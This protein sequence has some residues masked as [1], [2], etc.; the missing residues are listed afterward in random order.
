[1]PKRLPTPRR[2]KKAVFL[3]N[4]ISALH[5]DYKRFAHF[6]KKTK[7]KH[8]QKHNRIQNEQALSRAQYIPKQ[9]TNTKQGRERHRQKD[10]E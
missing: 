3:Y 9:H 2:R 1:M 7:S 5:S 4:I 8:G 6:N 10:T